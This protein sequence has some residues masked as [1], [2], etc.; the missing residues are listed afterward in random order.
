MSPYI[1]PHGDLYGRWGAVDDGRGEDVATKGGTEA[2]SKRLFCGMFVSM[3][4]VCV[5]KGGSM[6]WRTDIIAALKKLGGTGS[7]EDIYA[8]LPKARKRGNW[9]STVRSILQYHDPK[10]SAY[11]NGEP[12]FQREAWGIWRLR[13]TKK[14]ATKP[15]AKTSRTKKKG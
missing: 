2:G 9:Q 4:R 5:L 12:T 10:S 1:R 7:L 6:T 3:Y 11:K 14:A 8:K 15:K 13:K